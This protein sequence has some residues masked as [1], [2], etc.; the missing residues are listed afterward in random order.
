MKGLSGGG[1]RRTRPGYGEFWLGG[2]GL[3]LGRG[4]DRGELPAARRHLVAQ[5]EAP[6]VVDADLEVAV[7]G[8]GPA[9]DDGDDRKAP[10]AEM[11]RP[12][13][14]FSVGTCIA[15]DVES[16]RAL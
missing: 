7:R 9:A 11:E 3:R 6:A 2:L 14:F 15:K 13:S 1:G 10:P 16:H 5:H 4:E 8:V 12:G